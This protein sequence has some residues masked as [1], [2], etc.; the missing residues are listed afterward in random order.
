MSSN[1]QSA[2]CVYKAKHYVKKQIT[3]EAVLGNP[4]KVVVTSLKRSLRQLQREL[5]ILEDKLLV[6]VKQP[7][8]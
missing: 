4:S 6:L 1:H 2:F 5:K 7:L 3:W 8:C